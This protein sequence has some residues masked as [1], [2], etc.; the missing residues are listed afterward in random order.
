MSVPKLPSSAA[1]QL[2][3]AEGWLA[4]GNPQ[5]ARQE[6]LSLG[7]E[8]KGHPLVL[9]RWWEVAAAMKDWDE[10]LRV[11]T[12][13]LD[14]FPKDPT[15]WVHRSYA[16]RRCTHGGLQE[17]WDALAPAVARFPKVSIIP[18]N[19]ACY[20]SQLGKLSEAW[21]WLNKAIEAG[22]DVSAVKVLALRDEDLRPLWD[23]V[24]IL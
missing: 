1:R 19:I 15:G 7:T 16:L 14:Q 17:A 8:L 24:R 5:E 12:D 20:A 3:A 10:A 13:Q 4:L 23:R 6:L 18:Y 11:A 9:D 21:D 2:E 22:E